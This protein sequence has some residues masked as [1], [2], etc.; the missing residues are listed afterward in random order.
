MSIP[1][2]GA[3]SLPQNLHLGFEVE[4]AGYMSK[5][6]SGGD[7]GCDHCIDGRNGSAVVFCCACREF[8]C[9]LCYEHH[10]SGRKLSKHSMVEMNHEGAKQLQATMKPRE[11]YCTQPNHEDNKLNFYC[12][13]C[14]T[15]ICRDCTTVA[16][17]DHRVTELSTVAKAHQ[18]KIK[19][20][21]D[22]AS[23]IVKK[24][25]GAIE[26]DDRMIEQVKTSKQ[27]AAL[28]L[29]KAFD[30]LHQTLEK[31]KEELLS[32]LDAIAQTKTSALTTQKEQFEKL[33]D[34]FNHF[35]EVASHTI[36][37][38]TDRELVALGGL[39][40][41]ELQAAV[42][43]A[44]ATP[45]TPNNYSYTSVSLHVDGLVEDL[46]KFGH[47][48]E[49]LPSPSESTWSP[50]STSVVRVEAKFNIRVKS[51][52][53]KGVEY[54]YGGAQVKAEMKFKHNGAVVYGEV[55]DHWDGTYTITLTPQTAGPHQL[56]VTMDGQPLQKSPHDLDVRPKPNYRSLYNAHQVIKCSSYPLCFAIHDS[57][58]IYVGSWANCIYVFDQ[59]GQLKNTI[60]SEGNGDGQ[61]CYPFGIAIKGDVLYVADYG[62]HRVQ[63]LTSKGEFLHQF[64]EKGSGQGQLNG[65]S[66]VIVDSKNRL[67]VSDYYNHRIQIFDQDG[68]WLM[69]IDGKGAGSLNP[70]GL[71]LDPQ[72]NLHVAAYGSNTI[73]VFTVQGVYIRMYGD[74][75]CPIGVAIDDDGYSLVCEKDGN[76]LSIIDPQGSKVHSVENLMGP[77]GAA[78]DPRDGSVYVANFGA[79][80]VL[81]YS[82]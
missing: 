36:Q 32:E 75:K 35:A 41:T 8:L 27:N 28:A 58:N 52:T 77:Y 66:A 79:S 74:L 71:A 56:V 59:K 69:T 63:K 81:K 54:P 11:H 18:K 34:D 39:M 37:T 19:A 78:L 44:Q 22:D 47:I 26:G 65:P 73:K 7:V 48:F 31:R 46:S 80:T 2:G 53:S 70:W 76:C 82:I 5:I 9:K 4:V 68:S 25:K 72:G 33:V 67:I 62:N 15:L 55:K 64:G 12:E 17:K 24:L 10:K 51:K 40:P 38:H 1:V 29:N 42:K 21:L 43:K 57:G 16:H 30:V 14:S 13:T 50:L 45:L 6:V 61:F 49:W 3:S 20:A 60:G 23:D